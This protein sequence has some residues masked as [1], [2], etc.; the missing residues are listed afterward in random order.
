MNESKVKTEKKVNKIELLNNSYYILYCDKYYYR[1]S[2]SQTVTSK[3]LMYIRDD[4]LASMK[5]EQYCNSGTCAIFHPLMS[6][7]TNYDPKKVLCLRMP[8][9]CHRIELFTWLRMERPHL[10]SGADHRLWSTEMTGWRV[11][12]KNSSEWGETPQSHLEKMTP[13]LT[14]LKMT[15]THEVT[16]FVHFFHF[17]YFYILLALWNRPY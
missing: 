11:R 10:M 3:F 2:F 1:C 8:N 12:W 16:V 7:F 15:V 6:H 14:T 4:S 5:S 9:L 13:S 17:W